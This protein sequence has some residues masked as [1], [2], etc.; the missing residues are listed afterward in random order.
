MTSD[1]RARTGPR[2]R[3]LAAFLAA[4]LAISGLALISTQT[5][6]AAPQTVTAGG[7]DWGVRSSFRSYVTGPIAHGAITLADGA[8]QNLDGTFHF[9]AAASSTFDAASG[10]P[11]A[12]FG[13]SVKFYGHDGMLDMTISNI[14]VVRSGSSGTLV[15]DVLSV[16]FEGTTPPAPPLEN[17]PNVVLAD[18]TGGTFSTTGTTAGWS[19]AAAVLTADGSDAFGGFYPAGDPLDPVSYSLTLQGETPPPAAA[20]SILW[21]VSQYAFTSTSLSP[22]PPLDPGAP[23]T[24]GADGWSFPSSTVSYDPATGVTDLSTTG[25]LVLGN[26]VQGGYRVVLANPSIHV[27]ADGAGSLSADVSSCTGTANCSSP[28]LSTPV[29][30]VVVNFTVPDAAVTDTGS[31]VSWT[32]TPDYPSQNN[33]TWPT[34][35]QFPQSFLDTLPES[36]RNHFRDSLSGTAPNQT[37]NVNNANKPP[38]PLTVSFAYTP[39]T[40]PP[41]GV[42]QQITTEVLENGGLTIS[43]ED[44]T[45]VLPTPLPSTD[46]TT[47][48]TSGAINPVTVTDLRLA[49]PGWNASG[50][51]SDFTGSAGTIDGSK[52]G[53]TPSLTSASGGQTATAGAAVAAGVGDGL[54]ASS[55]LGSAPAGAGRGTAIFGAGLEL[56]PPTTTPPGVYTATLTLTVI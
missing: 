37:P 28:G 51:V 9:P 1:P 23:A 36:L 42:T 50:Q 48:V 27:G 21:K 33:A 55:A 46:A 29:R 17:H 25:S 2:K 26:V 13:G 4:V 47:L 49:N 12:S 22:T 14:R 24:R 31:N 39:V 3:V 41:A 45:V 38:A 43:V 20:G 10:T 32:V 35:G 53:W 54:K 6:G 34:F 15:A 44:N 19:G 40:P 52:L 8:T 7:L 5:A 56:K 16:P 11:T 30:A 18:L